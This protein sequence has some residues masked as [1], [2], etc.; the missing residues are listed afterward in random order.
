M[1][2]TIRCRHYT[3]NFESPRYL[4][5]NTYIILRLDGR[6]FTRFTASHNF[7]KPN[8]PRALNLMNA[9][10]T[11]TLKAIPEIPI[12]Y[13]ISDEF[14]FLLPR[15]C[16]LFDR[17]E[18]KLVSTVVSTFTGWYVLLW[19]RYFTGE[20]GNL[21]SPPSFDCRAVCYPSVG[22]VR[23]YF[24]WRQVDAHVN[25]LYNTAFWALVNRGEVGR[26]EAEAELRGTFAADKNELLFSRFGIN[27][28]NEPEMYRKGSVVY[29]DYRI[30]EDEDAAATAT[31]EQ[32]ERAQETK[33]TTAVPKVKSKR[34]IE[35]E[36]KHARRARI[37]TEYVDIIGDEF[38]VKRPWLLGSEN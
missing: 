12:A 27:Y 29:R 23:D 16:S 10:A 3:R 24:A 35:K 11:E 9:S 2:L 25:N 15:E 22:N 33:E 30:P 4:L 1:A 21:R 38:W 8:D 14:S 32:K 17:R 36:T 26:R 18:E 6:S 37:V 31:Q 13:G 7:Q 28:N 19:S 5:P 20:G 34:Q